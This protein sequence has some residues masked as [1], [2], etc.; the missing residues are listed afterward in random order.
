VQVASTFFQRGTRHHNNHHCDDWISKK[1]GT[2]RN[3]LGQEVFVGWV[4]D[5]FDVG[6]AGCRLHVSSGGC[7]LN[8]LGRI[9]FQNAGENGP[10]LMDKNCH[11]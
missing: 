4:N 10:E 1:F 5:T 9:F 11:P 8:F 2:F 3:L 7:N 6:V